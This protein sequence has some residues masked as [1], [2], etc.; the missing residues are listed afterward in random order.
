MSLFNL[1]IISIL[2][3]IFE[4]VNKIHSKIISKKFIFPIT[5]NIVL[6][7]K[8]LKMLEINAGQIC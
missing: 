7:Q 8:V 6:V 5:L 2:T 3:G 4:C 1:Q